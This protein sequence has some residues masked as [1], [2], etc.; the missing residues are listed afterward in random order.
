MIEVQN[1]IKLAK[2]SVVTSSV[3]NTIGDVSASC[4]RRSH[5]FHDLTLANTEIASYGVL[6]LNLRQL[7]LL[8]S[9]IEKYLG[10]KHGK[11]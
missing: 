8:G 5:N 6:A 1:G 11:T 4:L 10:V 7:T 3:G 9:T 2:N